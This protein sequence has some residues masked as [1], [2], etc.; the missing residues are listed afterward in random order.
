MD[1]SCVHQKHKTREASLMSKNSVQYREKESAVGQSS[2]CTAV[3]HNIHANAKT[4]FVIQRKV[5]WTLHS[6]AAAAIYLVFGPDTK[7]IT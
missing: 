6:N 7:I 2:T 1:F 5:Q 4:N 3:V